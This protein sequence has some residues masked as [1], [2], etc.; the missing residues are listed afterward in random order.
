M[1][2]KTSKPRKSKG[3]IE[4]IPENAV[5]EE[6][7][8]SFGDESPSD[9]TVQEE[10]EALSNRKRKRTKGSDASSKEK[11]K[12]SE[13]TSEHGDEQTEDVPTEDV[14]Y[15]KKARKKTSESWEYLEEFEKDG[16]KWARYKLCRT[17]LKRGPTC[18]T[19][20]LNRHV[21]RCK[22]AHGTRLKKQAQLQFQAGDSSSEVTL[23]NFRTNMG[24]W[25][26]SGLW[27]CTKCHLPN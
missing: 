13:L 14:P 12:V 20:S 25:S 15:T 1:K 19:S 7:G 26:K 4:V 24:G 18:S 11:E 21:N 9:D 22:A 17:E 23:A 10:Q 8:V 2:S 16:L 5:Y 27:M 6:Y 3:H